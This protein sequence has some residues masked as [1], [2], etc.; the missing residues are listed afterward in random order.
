[1]IKRILCIKNYKDFSSY[2]T[3]SGHTG[4]ISN[5]KLITWGM[6]SGLTNN[7]TIEYYTGQTESDAIVATISILLTAT[8]DD[9]GFLSSVCE[10]FSKNTV[11]TTGNTVTYN[12]NTYSCTTNHISGENFN[13]LYWQLTPTAQTSGN[14]VTYIGESRINEFRRYGK[15][16]DDIDLYNPAWNTGF[17]NA[18]NDQNGIIKRITGENENGSALDKQKLYNYEISI[19]GKTGTTISY[20][21]IGLGYSEISYKTYGLTNENS[22]KSPTI[23]LEYLNGIINNPKI[24]IDVFIDRGSNSSFDRHLRLGDIKSTT[25]LDNYGNGYFKIKEN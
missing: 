13:S 10:N 5:G 7:L 8:I 22:I 18:I 12:N 1:M 16:D 2:S 9:I 14:T 6:I 25:D 15:T 17:T 20:S 21:D 11:Y 24:N 4:D 23:K 19:S 3:W